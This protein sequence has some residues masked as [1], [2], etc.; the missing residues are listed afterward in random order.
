MEK[1]EVTILGCGCALPTTQHA[2]SSQIVN[3]REKLFMVDCGEGTQLQ[4]RRFHVNFQHINA[5]FISHLHG[6]HYYGLIGMLST[7]SMLDRTSP[8]HIYAHRDL[9]RLLKPQLDYFGGSL[10]YDVVFH[11][12]DTTRSEI[13]YD[14]R[15]LTVST[16]PLDHHIA[17]CGFLFHEK[18]TL[19]HIRRDMIDFYHIPNFAINTIKQ[20]ADWVMP[21]G[22]VI[23]NARLTRPADP[24]RS[25][26]YC[27]DTAYMPQLAEHLHNV[28]LLY[29]E[30][31]YLEDRIEKAVLY[32]HSTA[33]QAALV[34][35][36]ARVRRLLIGHFSQRYDTDD[37]FLDEAKTVFPDTILAKEGLRIVI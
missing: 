10:G 17:C 20:G 34:A 2:P 4:L 7:F 14:D 28:D 30:A 31:T 35:R 6:D 19:P 16:I 3:V 21:E 5:V 32:K 22:N 15:S 11:N 12:I 33:R 8:L 9:P 29:H 13:I 36:E 18:P 26:A 24:P 23:P 1:F 27:S 25:Y 37:V